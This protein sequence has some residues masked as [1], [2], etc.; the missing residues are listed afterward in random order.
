LDYGAVNGE[1]HGSPSSQQT[2]EYGLGLFRWRV[3]Q[4]RVMSGGM[5]EGDRVIRRNIWSNQIL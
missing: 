2:V 5:L 4:W 3:L 1:G